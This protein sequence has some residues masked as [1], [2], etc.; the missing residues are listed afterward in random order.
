M[1]ENYGYISI[2]DDNNS[3]YNMPILDCALNQGNINKNLTK[4][5]L[6]SSYK[7]RNYHTSSD[8][9]T[10]ENTEY[11]ITI[12]NSDSFYNSI[13]EKKIKNSS[14]SKNSIEKAL[15]KKRKI[16][17]ALIDKLKKNSYALNN[18]KEKSSRS[19]NDNQLDDLKIIINSEIVNYEGKECILVKYKDNH[20]KQTCIINVN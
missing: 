8:A 3:L 2:K 4:N 18:F 7:Y 17:S 1:F 9:S 15:L 16:S 12:S 20:E 14:S 10:A 11:S 19:Q 6:K 13:K 5:K